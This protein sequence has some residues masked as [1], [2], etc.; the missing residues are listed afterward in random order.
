MIGV[1]FF[2]E[3][4]VRFRFSQFL[5]VHSGMIRDELNALGSAS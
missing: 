4:F 3:S 5:S 1:G 2:S